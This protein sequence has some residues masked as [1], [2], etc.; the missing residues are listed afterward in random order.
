MLALLCLLSHRENDGKHTTPAFARSPWFRR[1]DRRREP[2]GD[3]G[4]YRDGFC[5]ACVLRE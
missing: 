4:A 2:D 5:A 1:D 3:G